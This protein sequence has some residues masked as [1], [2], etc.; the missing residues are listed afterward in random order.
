MSDPIV[1]QKEIAEQLRVAPNTVHQWVKRGLLP[2]PE[3]AVGGDPAWHWST[4]E[5]WARE[6]G[7]IPGLRE[8]ILDLLLTVSGASTSP[9]ASTLIARG[10]GRTTVQVW[11]VLN[12]LFHEGLLGYRVPDHWYVSDLGSQVVEAR[13]GGSPPPAKLW[14]DS[15][16]IPAV[17]V[18]PYAAGPSRPIKTMRDLVGGVDAAAV[19]RRVQQAVEEKRRK[20]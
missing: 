11:R 4:I 5:S 3:G 7:R 10:F 6:T 1:G 12:D 20:Q 14:D 18:P 2:P 13:R 17:Y 9:I 15:V 19:Q 8:A 16:E